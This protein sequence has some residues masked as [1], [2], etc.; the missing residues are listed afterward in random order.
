MDRVHSTTTVRNEIKRGTVTLYRGNIFRYKAKVGQAAYQK[1]NEACCCHYDLLE[2]SAFISYVEEHF[3]E[4]EWSLD[5]CAHRALK[6]GTFTREQIVCTKTPY[7]YADL[8]LLN[9]R[10]IDLPEKL[11][12]SPKTARGTA[13]QHRSLVQQP[14][15]KNT[16]LQYPG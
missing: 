14:S 11:H 10:N 7:V 16:R 1:N 12:R 4:D 6:D 3:F 8:G 5:V 13:S 2:K 9:I 15:E